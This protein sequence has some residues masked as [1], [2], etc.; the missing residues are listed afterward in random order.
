M[1]EVKCEYSKYIA[2]FI[3]KCIKCQKTFCPA[4]SVH[5]CKDK[6]MKTF[7]VTY[8][9]PKATLLKFVCNTFLL[10]FELFF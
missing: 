2:R 10:L 9:I 8:V 1:C 5:I 7:T 3:R 4:N 6:F